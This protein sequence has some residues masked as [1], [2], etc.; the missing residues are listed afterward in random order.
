MLEAILFTL[1]IDEIVYKNPWLTE[2][3][4]S[5]PSRIEVFAF[6]ARN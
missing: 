1:S 6:S 5:M 3:P 2:V 4:E